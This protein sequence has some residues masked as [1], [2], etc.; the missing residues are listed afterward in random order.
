[1]SVRWPVLISTWPLDEKKTTVRGKYK[2]LAD[3][4]RISTEAEAV[5]LVVLNGK[6]GSGF[7]GHAG[8]GINELLPSI[9]RRVADDISGH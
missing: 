5:V 1:M 3:I 4:V 6:D 7:S 8:S 2:D 9:L